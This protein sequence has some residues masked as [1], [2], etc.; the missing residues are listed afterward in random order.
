MPL[1]T[2]SAVASNNPAVTVSK[3]LDMSAITSTV[4]S[5]LQ[6]EREKDSRRLNLIIHG[7]PESTSEIPAERKEHDTELVAMLFNQ[8][9]KIEISIDDTIRFGKKDPTKQRLLKISIPSL[10]VKKSIFRNSSK[11]R[12]VS[13]PDW[14]KKVFITPYLTPKE[15][16]Q[17][18]ELR[19]QLADLNSSGK[20]Y[21]IKNGTIVRKEGP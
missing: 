7:I 3:E 2:P 18:K 6:E 14:M 17:S 12:D 8:H 21:Q 5:M 1:L 15:Q 11:L 20:K 13:D 4:A 9:L 19:K 16:E 10:S